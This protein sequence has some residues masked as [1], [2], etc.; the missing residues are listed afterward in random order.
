[1]CPHRKSSNSNIPIIHGLGNPY[2]FTHGKAAFES[3]SN[4]FDWI[5]DTVKEQEKIEDDCKNGWFWD[6]AEGCAK[7]CLNFYRNLAGQICFL[8]A[9][10]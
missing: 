7:V 2:C 6:G 4:N 9:F 3:I 1:M 5:L 8:L 10:R